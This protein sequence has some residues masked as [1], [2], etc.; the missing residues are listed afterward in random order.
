[1]VCFAAYKAFD[2]YAHNCSL[3]DIDV[4]VHF[5]QVAFERRRVDHFLADD[6]AVF[7]KSTVLPART[8]SFAT[9]LAQLRACAPLRAL[10]DALRTAAD[11]SPSALDAL[12][13][14][15]PLIYWLT[16]TDTTCQALPRKQM[17]GVARAALRQVEHSTVL[18]RRL[19]QALLDERDVLKAA[20]VLLDALNDGDDEGGDTARVRGV[21]A[22]L[23][24]HRRA[25]EH[26]HTGDVV[27]QSVAVR[28]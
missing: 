3:E 15:V 4:F 12:C 13:G 8:A 23:A 25:Q 16:S 27:F 6:K 19:A 1:M 26:A 2:S 7:V 24:L 9:V 28:F 17:A 11:S 20:R 21:R 18:K 22:Q 14:A 5:S 10:A